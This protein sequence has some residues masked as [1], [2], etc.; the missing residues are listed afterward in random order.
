MGAGVRLPREPRAGKIEGVKDEKGFVP[1]NDKYMTSCEGLYAG[2]DILPR[3]T[4]QIYLAIAD[5][6]AIADTIIG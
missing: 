2:G 4:R 6:N 3:D 1:V 5:A